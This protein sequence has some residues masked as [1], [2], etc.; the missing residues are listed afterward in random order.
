MTRLEKIV[1][2]QTRKSKPGTVGQT[3]STDA[4]NQKAKQLKAI[5]FL[6]YYVFGK[7]QSP[8]NKRQVA[9]VL[10]KIS[11]YGDNSI[12]SRGEYF[13]V[14][15]EDYKENEGTNK[16]VIYYP[17]YIIRQSESDIES[18]NKFMIGGT[19]IAPII[20]INDFQNI[21]DTIKKKKADAEAAAIAAAE[22]K[23]PAIEITKVV[24][25]N[26]VKGTETIN[27]NNLGKGTPDADAFQE[28]MWQAGNKLNF[29]DE[30]AKTDFKNFA[31]YR[32]KGLDG[33]WDGD[34]GDATLDALYQFV[35]VN[36]ENLY[37][38]WAA[39]KKAEVIEELRLTAAA[40]VSESINYFKGKGMNVKLK[41]LLQEQ[42]LKEQAKKAP[43][44][45]RRGGSSGAGGGGGGNAGGGVRTP[46]P[47]NTGFTQATLPAGYTGTGKI[48]YD[49]GD[50]FTGSWVNGFKSGP[51]I[52]K[53][54]TG[55]IYDGTWSNGM[56]N[57]E[58]KITY[59]NGD[60]RVGTFSNSVLS[61]PV[62]FTPKGGKP[63]EELWK[64]GVKIK[65]DQQQW[66][67]LKAWIDAEEKWWKAGSKST[68]PAGQKVPKTRK[69]MFAGMNFTFDPDDV[70]GKAAYEANRKHA[71]EWLESNLDSDNG[72]NWYSN[73]SSWIDRIADQID[74]YFQ[75]VE[76]VN[77]TNDE[78]GDS[79]YAKV[80]AEMF[81]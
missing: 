65:T 17:I 71:L 78:T 55:K 77:I 76:T 7:K 53:F 13:Y 10:P 47:K 64:D 30:P 58:F 75:N 29:T 28:L 59:P 54:K 11:I 67:I 20:D 3:V 40:T 44:G 4:V 31:Y 14:I 73:V 60:I 19:T 37:D 70:V 8:I 46:K 25:Q 66:E 49:S 69:Q 63:V 52:Y 26:V 62:T 6:L 72:S 45:T 50:K 56:K 9:S 24:V 41:D 12:Y 38:M 48:T 39:G 16:A 1:L 57:G 74:D 15:G 80:E 21:Q 36:D 22:K 43:G 5:S 2:E 35:S 27:V 32:T 18:L 23:K 79:I 42:L 33:G 81:D 51:G 61:G 68:G 34:I